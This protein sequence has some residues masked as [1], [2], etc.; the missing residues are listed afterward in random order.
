[1]SVKDVIPKNVDLIH[2]LTSD[3]YKEEVMKVRGGYANKADVLPICTPSALC[4]DTFSD[5]NVI[6]HTGLLCVDIDGKD[7]IYSAEHM[8]R[9]VSGYN[10]V[11]Y[12]GLSASGKGLAVLVKIPPEKHQEAFEM[13]KVWFKDEL[14][15]VID[16]NCGNIARKRFYSYD[17]KFY[18]NTEATELDV[19]E[20]E[21]KPIVKPIAGERTGRFNVSMYA[22]KVLQETGSRD[23]MVYQ[24]A[25]AAFREGLSWDELE[26]HF[27]YL[28]GDNKDGDVF[29]HRQLT[30]CL[31]QANKE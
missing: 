12:A 9:L 25:K 16:P 11:F 15:I 10:S 23:K 13:L 20:V 29:T 31:R 8:K 28:I 30:K 4:K 14:D 26:A 1:M 6:T 5:S 24:T 2:F 19:I 18:L 21:K 7:N 22:E 3:R 27:S 17:P